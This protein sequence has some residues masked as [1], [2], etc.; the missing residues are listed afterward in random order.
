MLSMSEKRAGPWA[1]IWRTVFAS[2]FLLFGLGSIGSGISSRSFGPIVFGVLFAG[3]GAF[4]VYTGIRD[5][6]SAES[7]GTFMPGA[8]TRAPLGPAAFGGYRAAGSTRTPTALEVYGA[9]LA[10]LPLAKLKPVRGRTHA[11]ALGRRDAHGGWGLLVFAIVW[12]SMT[13]PFFIGA[14]AAKSLVALFLLIFVTVG[15]VMLWVSLKRILALRKVVALEIDAEPAY[16]GDMLGLHLAQRGPVRINS[17]TAALVCTEHVTYRVGTDTRTEEREVYRE[18][19]LDE[20]AVHVARGETWTRQ[21][22]VKLPDGPPSFRSSNNEVAWTIAIKSDIDGW[23]DYAEAFV[24]RALP[25]V[26]A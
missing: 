23:P 21:L 8:V 15:T 2:P 7:R 16:L 1:V 22:H 12:N 6:R 20:V 10:F 18:E 26:T 14:V 11:Y 25:K 3:A 24:F 19:L 5:M 4:V 17:L 13:W 9:Q